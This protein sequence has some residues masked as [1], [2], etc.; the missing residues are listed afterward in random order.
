MRQRKKVFALGLFLVLA[1]FAVTPADASSRAEVCA[2]SVQQVDAPGLDSYLAAVDARSSHDVWAVGPSLHSPAPFRGQPLLE[3]WDGA[4]WTRTPGPQL[5]RYAGLDDVSIVTGRDVWA[6][7]SVQTPG[8]HL[9]FTHWN[10]ATWKV[11]A[12]PESDSGVVT[13]V[14]AASS[15]DVWAVGWHRVPAGVVTRV[16]HWD[17]AAWTLVH[18][19]RLLGFLQAIEVRGT[20]VVA[21]GF[22]WDVSTQI[23]APMMLRYDG[24]RWREVPLPSVDGTLSDVS[25]RWAVGARYDDPSAHDAPLVLERRHGVWSVATL[26][27]VSPYSGLNAVAVA[28]PGDVWAFGGYLVDPSDPDNSEMGWRLLHWDG[29]SWSVA[30]NPSAPEVDYGQPLGATVAPDTGEIWAV[31]QIDQVAGVVQHC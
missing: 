31:G 29:A 16:W 4:G 17:G 3:H 13:G 2:W 26:P 10:G 25:G 28:G 27:A 30:P 24:A 11:V 6:V 12:P 1:S 19:P 5:G 23:F 18:A 21:V 9:L 7:G 20:A 15:D 8:Y 22:H 14:A